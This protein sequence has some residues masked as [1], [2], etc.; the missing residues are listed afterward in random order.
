M[1]TL[2]IKF[3]DANRRLDNF[4]RKKYP[5]LTLVHIFKAIRTKQIKVNS[6]KSS[7]NYRLQVND[8]IDIFIND[9][10]LSQEQNKM[11]FLM[12]P[13]DINI[14][15]E[16]KNILLVNKPAGLTVHEDL[17]FKIDILINRILHYLYL[18]KQWDP[19]DEH[20]FIPSLINRIDRNTSG[21]VIAAKNAESLRILNEKMRN[22]EIDKYY[23]ATVH[24]TF[25]HKSGVLKHYL[26]KDE[27]QNKVTITNK[28]IN[29]NSKQIITEY[30][31]LNTK[32]DISK[33]EIK[34][35]TG[36]THQI[37]AHFA[38][39][40]HPLVGEKKYTNKTFS[41]L[42]EGIWQDLSAYKVC[43]KFKTDA[44]ILNYLNN[45]VFSII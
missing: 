15:Y 9:K 17:N 4:L 27:L 30:K 25:F 11:D 12:A 21:I 45:K 38:F 44:G 5:K 24:G 42:N 41:K 18:K 28:P 8:K 19:N 14:V 22:R 40:G 20:T 16:D 2:I 23:L 35:V 36:K 10:F 32:N 26:T 6:K 37:R 31:I 3:N 13:S 7:N 1:K 34:L 29:S 43:F 33:L 39:I